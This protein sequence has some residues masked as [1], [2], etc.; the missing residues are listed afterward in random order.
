MN[1]TIQY[2]LA[3]AFLLIFGSAAVFSQSYRLTVQEAKAKLA[4]SGLVEQIQ[5]KAKAEAGQI[6]TCE[7]YGA[8]NEGQINFIVENFESKKEGRSQLI[9]LLEESGQKRALFFVQKPDGSLLEWN[10]SDLVQ[11]DLD[12]RFGCIDPGPEPKSKCRACLADVRNCN[13]VAHST[14]ASRIQC[15]LNVLENHC[16]DCKDAYFNVYACLFS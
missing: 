5:A 2:L 8:K 3:T 10:G 14:V 4:E 13:R 6:T 12:V 15:I 9:S 11:I 7:R 1:K 16:Q